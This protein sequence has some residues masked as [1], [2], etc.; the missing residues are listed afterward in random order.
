MAR[1][2][3]EM[4]KCADRPCVDRVVEDMTQWSQEMARTRGGNARLSEDDIPTAT[5][6]ADGMAKCMSDLLTSLAKDKPPS[7]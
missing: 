6:I 4:C 3:D 1:F 5:E 2:R 7:P